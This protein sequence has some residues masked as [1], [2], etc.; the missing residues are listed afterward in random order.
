MQCKE[1]SCSTNYLSNSLSAPG[2]GGGVLHSAH[3]QRYCVY[4]IV[5]I[6]SHEDIFRYISGH[7][8]L[9]EDTIKIEQKC[10]RFFQTFSLGV[11]SVSSVYR[12]NYTIPNRPVES[13]KKLVRDTLPSRFDIYIQFNISDREFLRLPFNFPDKIG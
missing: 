4:Y 1:T 6:N 2:G 13:A 12:E 8:V 9:D 11:F 7:A 3:C 5:L 10:T